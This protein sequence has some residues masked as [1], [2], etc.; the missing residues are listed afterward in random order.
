[1]SRAPLGGADDEARVNDTLAQW[2]TTWSRSSAL[3][4]VEHQRT[5]DDRGHF[6]WLVR[7]RGDER[8][9]MT[10]WLALRQRTIHVECEITPAPERNRE[11]V[12]RYALVKNADLR[13]VHVA[14][15]PE[16]GLYLMT[17]VPIHEFTVERLDEVMG[18]IVVY[19]D[20]LY[21]TMMSSAFAWFR[22]RVR[23]GS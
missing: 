13:E 6:H 7:L 10:V 11:E 3:I 5:A 8:E 12:Y 9:V 22:R 18:A 14:L 15:G 20:E 23:R 17:H 1:V 21:P 19:V 16:S 4:G 2:A